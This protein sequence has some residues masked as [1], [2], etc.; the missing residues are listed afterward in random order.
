MKKALGNRSRIALEPF[1][2]TIPLFYTIP[3]QYTI[4]IVPVDE[5]GV[6]PQNRY[7]TARFLSLLFACVSMT[8]L[9]ISDVFPTPDSP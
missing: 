2:M 6:V 3:I 9:D 1:N 7:M 8:I 4:T 5:S